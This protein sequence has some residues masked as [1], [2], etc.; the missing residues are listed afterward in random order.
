MEGVGKGQIE[1]ED[2]GPGDFQLVFIHL[3]LLSTCH[4][5]VRRMKDLDDTWLYGPFHGDSS[6]I[7]TLIAD[8]SDDTRKSRTT[9]AVKK[10]RSILKRPR[11][12]EVLLRGSEHIRTSRSKSVELDSRPFFGDAV[13]KRVE[14]REEVEQYAAVQTTYVDDNDHQDEFDHWTETYQSKFQYGESYDDPVEDL[15]S[16]TQSLKRHVEQNIKMLENYRHRNTVEKLDPAPLKCPEDTSG[17]DSST[18]DRGKIANSPTRCYNEPL[19]FSTLS[20][21]TML[22][23]GFDE[24]EEDWL[25]PSPY[26]IWKPTIE[27]AITSQIPIKPTQNT[28]KLSEVQINIDDQMKEELTALMRCEELYL[29]PSSSDTSESH[30][31][32]SE[33]VE[34]DDLAYVSI[35]DF[36]EERSEVREIRS[37]PTFQEMKQ[38]FVDRV[39][40]DFYT[41]EKDDG[42]QDF[43]S[44]IPPDLIHPAL[45][46]A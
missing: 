21:W 38:A 36:P 34:H 5:T 10:T 42:A 33:D 19:R 40:E 29:E 31:S 39:M 46:A 2:C 6:S 4:L 24:E 15:L 41:C 12:S 23:E 13:K 35:Q 18:S 43:S 14:F 37:A 7:T 16:T 17:L 1:F 28:H 25:E 9:L 32:G 30:S 20:E 3:P 26:T 8:Y 45:K 27:S 11:L 22:G 44:L